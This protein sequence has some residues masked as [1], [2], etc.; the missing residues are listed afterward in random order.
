MPERN[1][2]GMKVKLA[3]ILSGL[4]LLVVSALAIPAAAT[5]ISWRD[6][7]TGFKSIN[8]VRQYV[9]ET[10]IPK[11]RY[12]AKDWDCEDYALALAQQGNTDNKTIGLMVIVR[13]DDGRLSSLH[14]KNF[15]VIYPYLYEVEPQNG[16]VWMMQ[17][18][19]ARLD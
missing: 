6:Y 17:G 14:M 19:E 11:M 5:P 1:G 7:D 8:E 16:N 15:T 10:G 4:L 2:E 3:I 12:V 9:K 13:Y 18:Y